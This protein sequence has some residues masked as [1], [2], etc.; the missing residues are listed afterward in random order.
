MPF[1]RVRFAI[2]TALDN[3]F[4]CA[5]QSGKDA[6]DSLEAV[7]ETISMEGNGVDDSE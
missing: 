5:A 1:L 2:M 7:R 4:Y 6:A 3:N